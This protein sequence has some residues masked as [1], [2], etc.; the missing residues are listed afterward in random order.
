MSGVRLQ[1]WR[2]IDCFVSDFNGRLFLD[3]S[4]SCILGIGGLC[5][6]PGGAGL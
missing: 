4:L 5:V 6:V 1:R 3:L 2:A